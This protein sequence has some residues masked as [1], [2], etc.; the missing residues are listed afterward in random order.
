MPR[1]RARRRA[2]NFVGAFL[3][4]GIV[5]ALTGCAASPPPPRL[6]LNLLY[7]LDPGESTSFDVVATRQW[8]PSGVKLLRGKRY[9][10]RVL[11]DHTWKDASIKTGPTGYE[12]WLL[13]PFQWL[14]RNPSQPW[15]TL[16]GYVNS[17]EPQV[18]PIGAYTVVQPKADGELSC[19]AN[20][21]AFAYDNNSGLLDLRIRRLPD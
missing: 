1:R 6:P 2:R 15:F 3:L 16:M 19:Y 21:A 4:A 20:D 18:F 7:P 14:R 11:G 8:N 13:A 5:L 17:R 10:L 9:E 12:T